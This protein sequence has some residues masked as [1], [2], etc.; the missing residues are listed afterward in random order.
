MYLEEIDKRKQFAYPPFSRI[1]QLSFK[2]KIREVVERGAQ[3]FTDGLKPRY[4]AYIVGPA[5]PTVNRVR[6]QYLMELLIKLPRDTKTIAQCKKEILEQ[7][8]RL[9]QDKSFKSV[10]IVPDVDVM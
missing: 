2:H 10:V 6:N 3:V 8:A 7:V 9:H 1:I 4:G 5:E